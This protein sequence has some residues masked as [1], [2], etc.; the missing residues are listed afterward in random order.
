[1]A[2]VKLVRF[3]GQRKRNIGLAVMQMLT[4]PFAGIAAHRI[5]AAFV[6]KPAQLFENADQRERSRAVCPR[7][8]PVADRV[9]RSNFELR[10]G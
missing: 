6:T 1:M 9:Q 8:L 3:P 5:I 2:P 4:L 10:R 7:S